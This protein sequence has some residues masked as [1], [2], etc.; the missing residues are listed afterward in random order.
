MAPPV[1][2]TETGTNNVAAVDSVTFVRGPF[3]LF[4]PFNFSSDQR[5]RILFFT[6]DLGLT[7]PNPGLLSVQASGFPLTVENVGPVSGVPGLN[8][9]YIVVRL[10]DGLPATDLQLTV[11]LGNATSN[12]AVLSIVP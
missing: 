4:N 8:A 7:Q 2:I 9:S 5:T 1:I 10:P 3:R 11:T 12:P 6:S